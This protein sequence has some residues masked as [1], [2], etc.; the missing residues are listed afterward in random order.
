MPHAF[1]RRRPDP[2]PAGY[3]LPEPVG[4]L[5]PRHPAERLAHLPAGLDHLGIRGQHRGDAGVKAI[6]I[7]LLG[8]GS[9]TIRH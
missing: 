1:G 7:S 6:L 5:R 3:S 9:G 4:M 8:A 2:R